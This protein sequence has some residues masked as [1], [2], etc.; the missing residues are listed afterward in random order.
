M[1]TFR[2]WVKKRIREADVSTDMLGQINNVVYPP[3]TGN[4]T[5][6]NVNALAKAIMTKTPT[7]NKAITDLNAMNTIKNKNKPLQQPIQPI[8]PISPSAPGYGG[9]V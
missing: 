7:L 9:I 8:A 2:E 4:G 3:V 6:V 1:K 5:P